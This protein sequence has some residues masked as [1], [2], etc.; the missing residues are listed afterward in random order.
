VLRGEEEM[1]CDTRSH[2]VS[3]LVEEVRLL[4]EM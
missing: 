2:V 3:V 1:D 4:P